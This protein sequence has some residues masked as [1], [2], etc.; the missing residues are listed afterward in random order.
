[1]YFIKEV[2]TNKEAYKFPVFELS[3]AQPLNLILGFFD[4]SLFNIITNKGIENIM[5]YQIIKKIW[6]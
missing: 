4:K 1:M 6:K 2:S 3:Y 5:N